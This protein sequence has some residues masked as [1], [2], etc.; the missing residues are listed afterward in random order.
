MEEI[1]MLMLW[2][3]AVTGLINAGL[4]AYCAYF[5]YHAWR[6][7]QSPAAHALTISC[8]FIALLAGVGAFGSLTEILRSE[9]HM[10][11][12]SIVMSGLTL[13]YTLVQF[14]FTRGYFTKE[15][16]DGV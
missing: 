5:W 15:N 1:R 13:L 8:V 10:A 16:F 3:A 2:I 12:I 14:L 4:M 9:T 6:W 11:T 7:Y